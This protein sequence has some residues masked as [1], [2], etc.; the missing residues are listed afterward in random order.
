MAGG[1]Y[2]VVGTG[3]FDGDGKTDL[4]FESARGAYVTWLLNDNKI[5]GGATLGAPGRGWV[6]KGEATNIADG[7]S[8]TVF[9]NEETG[10][11]A[12]W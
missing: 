11:L 3:D 6:L 7:T 12:T 1:S 2:K 10:Q 9:L 8:D 4:L 5:V